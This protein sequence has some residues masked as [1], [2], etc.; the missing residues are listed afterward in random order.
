MKPSITSFRLHANQVNMEVAN[1]EPTSM[2]KTNHRL[3]LRIFEQLGLSSVRIRLGR[4]EARE[5]CGCCSAKASQDER[6]RGW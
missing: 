5:D 1:R 6:T 2:R 4:G 3:I